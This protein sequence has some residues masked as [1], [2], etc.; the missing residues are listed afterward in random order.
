M[1]PTLIL[2]GLEII[3]A[4]VNAANAAKQFATLVEA[5]RS[6]DRQITLAELDALARANETKLASTLAAL[7]V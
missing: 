7:R 2:A 4:A 1:N 6:E 5:A 3:M